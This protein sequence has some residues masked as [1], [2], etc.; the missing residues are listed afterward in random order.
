MTHGRRQVYPVLLQGSFSYR[1]TVVVL[2]CRAEAQA[3]VE[4]FRA[5][6]ALVVA[7]RQ[8][9]VPAPHGFAAYLFDRELP[10]TLALAF[11]ADVQP[12]QVTVED[13]VVMALGERSHD[14]AD[15]LV[16]IVDKPG[17]GNVGHRVGVCERPGNGGDEVF[18]VAAQFQPAS[19]PDVVLGY[20][21]QPRARWVAEQGSRSAS[22]I[23]V[24]CGPD[25][26]A[27]PEPCDHNEHDSQ[28]SGQ[29]E[30]N[31]QRQVPMSAEEADFYALA[32]F[33]DE[34]QQEHQDDGE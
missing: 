30:G 21:L 26:D 17:P 23:P 33:Q 10:V 27:A 6:L 18:L 3:P 16:A 7:D 12:P 5:V 19:R 4:L 2:T 20:R 34:Y 14:K 13:R 1:L 29:Q 8:P 28:H 22:A 9:G 32:V 15:Q 31:T 11:G 25:T 24:G